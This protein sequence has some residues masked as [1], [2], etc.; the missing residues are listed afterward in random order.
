[1]G[2]FETQVLARPENLLARAVLPGR[3]IDAAHDRRSPK[4]I[5]LDMDGSES[6]VHG[7]QEGAACT[8]HLTWTEGEISMEGRLSST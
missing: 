5:T 1:M 3:W 8:G 2:R 4:S 7:D 6:P